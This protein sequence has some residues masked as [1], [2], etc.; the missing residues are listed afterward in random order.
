MSRKA[1]NFDLDVNA[2]KKH[3]SK[4]YNNAYYEINSFLSK[5]GFEHRQGSGYISKADMSN[6]RAFT[7]IDTMCDKFN[8]LEKCAKKI[9]ITSIGPT[10]DYM[11]ERHNNNKYKNIK[12]I[13]KTSNISQSINSN[14]SLKQSIEDEL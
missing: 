14:F 2:L 13:N 8:W 6:A 4:K 12:H 11:K 3:Y 9:D 5:N 10:F 1:I 7:V